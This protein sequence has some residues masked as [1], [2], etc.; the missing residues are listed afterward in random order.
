[1]EIGSRYEE[2]KSLLLRELKD[3]SYRISID[4]RISIGHTCYFCL[5]GI[6]YGEEMVQIL[7]NSYDSNGVTQ[8]RFFADL[9]CC[10][11]YSIIRFL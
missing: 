10:E 9:G 3:N 6:G 1:M 4:N 11:K 8:E 7:R 2:N 5:E